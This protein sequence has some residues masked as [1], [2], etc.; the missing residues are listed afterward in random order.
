MV[1]NWLVA[2]VSHG[3]FKPAAFCPH[4]VECGRHR[5]ATLNGIKL[6]DVRLILEKKI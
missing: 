5:N 3:W 2:L 6:Q 4:G 1:G